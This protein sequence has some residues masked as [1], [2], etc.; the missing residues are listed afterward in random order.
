MYRGS[1]L[2][3]LKTLLPEFNW[4]PLQ[5]KRA[6]QRYWD[7][8]DNQKAFFER[9]RKE[10]NLQSSEDW[11]TI[12]NQTLVE[13]R[14]SSLLRKYSGSKMLL[15]KFAPE[16]IAKWRRPGSYLKSETYLHRMIQAIFP[17]TELLRNIRHF[18]I[19]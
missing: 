14:G 1:K 5:F 8:E 16:F 17:S 2:N 6:P 7:D 18:G 13:Y 3:M 12:S 15:K 11:D 10:L 9:L 4:D 19:C